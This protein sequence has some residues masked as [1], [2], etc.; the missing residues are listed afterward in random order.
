MEKLTFT[1]K[2]FQKLQLEIES[3]E[4][5]LRKVQAQTAEAAE[6]GGNQWHD[7]AS[8]D[9]IVIETRGLDSR[10]S[11]AHETLNKAQVVA[12]PSRSDLVAIGTSVTIKLRGKI[13]TWEIAGFGESDPD[14]RIISY[15]T[16]LA[17]ILMGKKKGDIAY[18]KIGGSET[19]IEILNISLS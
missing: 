9:N 6:I 1:E 15:N 11:K 10:L 14:A 7:N 19:K 8:Y 13:K 3:L 16:P 17:S 18:G 12:T 4:K 2:G 5:K